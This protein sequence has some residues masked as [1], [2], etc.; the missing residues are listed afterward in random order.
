MLANTIEGVIAQQL[1]PKATG[2]GRVLCYEV[3]MGT[4]G[5]RNQI[6]QNAMHKIYSEIQGGQKYQMETM[7]H[8]LLNL[9]QRGEISYDTGV[10]MAR[11]PES[12]RER[13]A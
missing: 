5:V 7:D 8:C 3:L 13:L 6:R 12:I 9:Y 1:L 4:M 11:Y 2:K 10:S